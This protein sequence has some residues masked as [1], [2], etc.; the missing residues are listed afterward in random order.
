MRTLLCLALL[1]PCPAGGESPAVL[2]E[3][4][5]AFCES[6]SERGLSGWLEWFAADA[7]VLTVDGRLL[8]GEEA[9]ADYYTSL[10]FPPPGFR[11]EPE[12]G[13]LADSGDLGYTVGSWELRPPGAESA[14]ASTPPGG[15]Y[16]SVWKRQDDGT[17]LVLADAGGEPDYRK[18]L[19]APGG[20]PLDWASE[21]ERLEVAASGELAAAIGSWT[22]RTEA[23]EHRGRFVTV[24]IRTEAG[25]W[26]V[27]EE[28]GF[29][30]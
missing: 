17:F 30:Y 1:H 9:I 16:L 29:A 7:A 4:D 15:R 14:Q 26:E 22:A 11:W 12:S 6:T 20:P 25:G 13:A 2:L 10:A 24:W 23:G 19:A 27:A 28:I 3:A 21:T 5:R 18:R 8:E